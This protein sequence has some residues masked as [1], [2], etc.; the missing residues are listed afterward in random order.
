MEGTMSE[1]KL[2]W[3]EEEVWLE[4]KRGNLEGKKVQSDVKWEGRVR[5][6]VIVKI[7]LFSQFSL[8]SSDS[9]I[10]VRSVGEEGY[11]GRGW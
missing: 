7:V 4:R 9:S 1:E 11:I 2:E 8:A 6:S 5:T 3:G 10:G